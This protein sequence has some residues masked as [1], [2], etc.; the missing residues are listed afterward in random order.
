MRAMLMDGW[1][2]SMYQ[3]VGLVLLSIGLLAHARCSKIENR[4]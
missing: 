2:F 3:H 1:L 4:K